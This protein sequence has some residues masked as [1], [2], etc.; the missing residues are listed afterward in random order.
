MTARKRVEWAMPTAM[1]FLWFT[2]PNLHA[3]SAG[4]YLIKESTIAGGGG[5][6]TGG[7]YV[8][9]VTVGQHDAG[10]P[11][12]GGYVLTGGFRPSTVAGPDLPIPTVS[13]WGLVVLTLL[14]LTGGKIYYA[15]RQTAKA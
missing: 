8:L 3:Q 2:V 7:G 5:K 14:L 12:G 15:R 6:I 4:G 1:M 11:T 9:N 10:D 13:A